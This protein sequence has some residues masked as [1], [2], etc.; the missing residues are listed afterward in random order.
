MELA[1]FADGVQHLGTIGKLRLP[2]PPAEL[3]NLD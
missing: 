3:R 2:L 1:E